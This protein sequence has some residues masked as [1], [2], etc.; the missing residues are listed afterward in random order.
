MRM[1]ASELVRDR[2]DHV[3][4]IETPG[5]LRHVR[6]E[7]DLEQQVAQFTTQFIPI[8]IV[9]GFQNLVRLFQRVWFDGIKSLLTIP[10]TPSRATQ[11]RHDRNCAFET[12]S[13]SWHGRSSL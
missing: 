5:F 6:V 9:D 7:H 4:E 8:M 2:S 13:C 10:R 3:V 12:F 11:S 1:P